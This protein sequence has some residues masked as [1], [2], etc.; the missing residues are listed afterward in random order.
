MGSRCWARRCKRSPILPDRDSPPVVFDLHPLRVGHTQVTLDFFQDSQPLGAVSV[1]VEVTPYEVAEGA[2]PRTARPLQVDAEAEA[3]DLVLHI[4]YE[5]SSQELSFTLIRKGGIWWREMR[6]IALDADPQA[7]ANTLYGRLATL[8]DAEDPTVL[9]VLQRQRRIPL[10]DVDRRV[11]QL[12][13]NLWRSLIPEELKTLY[14]AEREQW[15]DQTLLILS[16]E[17]HLPWELVWPYEAGGWEDEGPWCQ[18]LQIDPLAAARRA[19]QRQRR[20]ARA[21]FAARPGGAGAHLF[22]AAQPGGGA[23]GAGD[24][25]GPGPA[26]RHPGCQPGDP[27]VGGGDGPAG[28]RG[29]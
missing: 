13:Q 5:A 15:R 12:G 14:A 16:D 18:T 9:A 1:G 10:Q 26:T 6:P 4:A 24:P 17:P 3:P 20:A 28:G 2:E 22:T 7:Y 11:K 21:P 8:L 19:G 23:G 29:L 27:Q 25:V